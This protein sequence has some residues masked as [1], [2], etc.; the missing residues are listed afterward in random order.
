RHPQLKREQVKRSKQVSGTRNP[1]F[2]QQFVFEVGARDMLETC[3][4]R[5]TLVHK[6]E[7]LRLKRPVGSLELHAGADPDS[8]PLLHWRELLQT[9]N[10]AVAR[11]HNLIT[12]RPRRETAR[13][14]RRRRSAGCRSCRRRRRRRPRPRRPREIDDDFILNR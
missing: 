13:S 11:W 10:R 12:P 6:T 8:L 1:Y 5:I 9:P 3:I 14:G 4:L 7:T 2:N